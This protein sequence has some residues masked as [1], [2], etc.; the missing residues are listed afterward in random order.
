MD[1]V[2]EDVKEYFPTIKLTG[3]RVENVYA[4]IEYAGF[5]P[6]LKAWLSK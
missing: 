5:V 4:G 3:R 6:K 1:E 2:A